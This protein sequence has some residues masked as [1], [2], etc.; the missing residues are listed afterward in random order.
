MQSIQSEKVIVVID[1]QLSEGFHGSISLDNNSSYKHRRIL[2]VHCKSYNGP[3][4]SWSTDSKLTR[5]AIKST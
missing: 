3:D 1:D 4:L 2:V 5:G